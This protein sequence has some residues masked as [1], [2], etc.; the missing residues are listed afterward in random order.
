MHKRFV[1][2]SGKVFG[3]WKVSNL[4]ES[5]KIGTLKQRKTFW[6]CE[7]SKCGIK[8]FKQATHLMCGASFGC[9]KCTNGRTMPLGVAA[10]NSLLRRY[11]RH[12]KERNFLWL[13]SD[14]DFFNLTT[15]NC[16][17]CG[18]PPS[19]QIR[20]K[21]FNGGYVYSGVDRKDNSIG[22]TVE[23]TV[24]CC[25]EC[26]MGKKAMPVEKFLKWINRIAEHQK[27]T[28]ITFSSGVNDVVNGG[29]EVADKN[30]HKN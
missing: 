17:Y 4:H 2:L 18:L 23:N 14:E 3:F 22:Y 28:C 21:N 13:L 1:D 16:F 7:C 25:A 11:K 29:T 19:S 20:K 26:N 10:A 24:A 8:Q 12:A 5:R 15:Q 6:L 30:G 9:R 27:T